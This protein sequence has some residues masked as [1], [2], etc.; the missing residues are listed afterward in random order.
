MEFRKMTLRA[1]LSLA[2]VCAMPA[3][4]SSCGGNGSAKEK[5][6]KSSQS[7]ESNGGRIGGP[8]LGTPGGGPAI[9][10]SGDAELQTMIKAVVPEFKQLEFKDTESGKTMKYNLYTPEDVDKDKKYPLVLF[11]ADASTPGTVLPEDGKGSEHMYSFDY[12]YK[13]RAVRDWLFKQKK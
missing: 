2:I 6:S 7:H 11:M 5:Q 9:D 12:A 8:Q 4:A 13:V 10:K 1:I 3:V